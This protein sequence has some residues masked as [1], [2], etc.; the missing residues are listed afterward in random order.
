M[1]RTQSLYYFLFKSIFWRL[2]III[3]NFFVAK[4]IHNI[5][6]FHGPQVCLANCFVSVQFQPNCFFFVVCIKNRNEAVYILPILPPVE[7]T[8]YLRL[9]RKYYAEALS[10]KRSSKT[11]EMQEILGRRMGHTICHLI[12]PV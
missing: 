11:F 6:V 10:T 5:N 8:M 7:L 4:V 12:I 9:S 3:C 2:N 1:L